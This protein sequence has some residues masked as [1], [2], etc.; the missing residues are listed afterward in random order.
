MQPQP[1]EQPEWWLLPENKERLFKELGRLREK[2]ASTP[3]IPKECKETSPNVRVLPG[4]MT[5]PYEPIPNPGPCEAQILRAHPEWTESYPFRILGAR[6]SDCRQRQLREIFN[7]R[8]H[9]ELQKLM[10]EESDQIFREAVDIE[11]ERR[12]LS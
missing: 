12:V 2:L 3:K 7:E 4:W 5:E 11:I 1:P 10:V 6:E 8:L 9:R